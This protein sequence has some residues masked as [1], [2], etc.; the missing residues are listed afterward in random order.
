VLTLWLFP[1]F[2]EWLRRT[3]LGASNVREDTPERHQQKKGTPTMGGVFI[4]VAV[5]IAAGLWADLRNW[6]VWTVLLV[7]IGFGA[8]GFV[9]DY[10]KVTRRNSA[11][12]PGRR[13]LLWQAVVLA[14][15]GGILAASHAGFLPGTAVE[16]D[17]RLAVPFVA[18]RW[19]NP[20]IGWL[21]VPFAML[22]VMF[23]SH[24]VNLTD[25]LDGLS[26]GPTIVSA[27]TF[28][29]L[30]YVT[31]LVLTMHVGSTVVDFNVAHYLNLPFVE[32]T[33]EAAI[34]C[35]AIAGAGVGFL[36]YNTFPASVFMGDVGSLALGG[37]LG[38]IAVLT[39]SEILSGIING[40]FMVEA[41]S[42]IVQVASF[43]LTG[44]RVFRMAPIHHH[45]EL[46]GWAEPKIIVRFWIM[47]IVLAL[48]GM[49][50]LKLR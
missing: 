24:A 37:A 4:L 3:Q 15:I 30:A 28:M 6:Y 7:M 19:F 11:G 21:Y 20:D 2:I 27:T 1:R 39:K 38:T 10:W 25:G 29:V 22:V 34:V 50:T 26:I 47:S 35:A 5:F 9:D 31:G 8:I 46:K 48:V 49:V 36:W 40:V 33:G 16:F 23:T 32:G 41:F 12:L 17:T 13:K 44:K 45:F 43:Q 18:V 14:V 42:V